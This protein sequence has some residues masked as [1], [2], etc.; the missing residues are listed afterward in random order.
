M[1]DQQEILDFFKLLNKHAVAYLVIGGAAVNIHGFSRATGD[2]DIWYNPT[3][4]NFLKV[5]DAIKDFGFDVSGVV[6]VQEYETKG[7]IR[8]PLHKF[9][10]ELIAIIDGKINFDDAYK[11]SIINTISNDLEIRVI[12]Y[13]DLLETKAMTRRPKDLEDIKQLEAA[14]KIH[15][16]NAKTGRGISG[17]LSKFFSRFK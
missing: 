6:K 17:F 2:L 12:G 10:I 4:E 9:Y 7:F 16:P 1:V 14:R 11:R 13:D 15:N 3:K 8:L 5:L